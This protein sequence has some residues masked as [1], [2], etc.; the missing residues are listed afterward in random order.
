MCDRRRC[1]S[2]PTFTATIWCGLFCKAQHRMYTRV[3]AEA[4]C[5]RYC[6]E[7]GLCVTVS[8]TQFIYTNGCENGVQVGLINYPR[9]PAEPEGIRNH[10]LEL[11]VRLMDELGQMRVSV[12]FPD[13]T[14]MLTSSDCETP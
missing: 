4:I 8:D 14:V 7:V 9:F 2:V 13:E 11:A 1:V 6:N 12:V 5:Q 3:M 10:A